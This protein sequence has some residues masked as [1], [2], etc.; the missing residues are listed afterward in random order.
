MG[1]VLVNNRYSKLFKQFRLQRGE[2][3]TRDELNR[4]FD[5]IAEAFGRIGTIRGKDGISPVLP[6]DGPAGADGAD[7]ASGSGGAAG[8]AGGSGGIGGAGGAGGGAGGA[9]GA[10]GDKG[11]K[12]DDGDP[13][14]IIATLCGGVR[15]T[16]LSSLTQ[17]LW[18]GFGNDDYS[19]SPFQELPIADIRSMGATSVSTKALLRV[20]DIASGSIVLETTLEGNVLYGSGD[21]S[22]P[23]SAAYSV[24]SAALTASYYNW[25]H[26]WSRRRNVRGSLDTHVHM[27]CVL[28]CPRPVNYLPATLRSIDAS[29]KS[30]NRIVV[31][32][33][34][35]LPKDAT[36]WQVVYAP[37]PQWE[38][39]IHN[40]FPFWKCIELA[41][42]AAE[43]LVFFEDDVKLCKNGATF[44]ESLT[45]PESLA[46]LSFFS[47]D[48]GHGTVERKTD[49][50]FGF[51]Q[52]AKF[53]LRTLERLVAMKHVMTSSRLGG[54]DTCVGII[55]AMFGWNH[56]IVFPN[57][58]QH[59]GDESVVTGSGAPKRMSPTFREEFDA[60]ELK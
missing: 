53:P 50:G 8:G 13:G 39:R 43:D 37:K 31:V 60:M 30:K 47:M 56:G 11:D 46:F 23:G 34:D 44:I 21:I 36:G 28:T 42:E 3:E 45:V 59:V 22:T 10:G 29:A 14:P 58:A 20:L 15:L 32:D 33:G 4:E 17:P 6:P 7:G 18:L 16:S 12:G 25:I 35:Y 41:F 9:G 54:S 52:A 19:S 40:R 26:A 51:L 48:N 27:I 1:L 49:R 5:L 2:K 55:G 38:Y 24:G 57:V